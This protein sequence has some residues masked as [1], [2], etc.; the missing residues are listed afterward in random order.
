[1]LVYHW[2]VGVLH[3]KFTIF[4]EYTYCVLVEII[5]TQNKKWDEI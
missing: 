1:M 2:Y 5:P 3:T 4:I